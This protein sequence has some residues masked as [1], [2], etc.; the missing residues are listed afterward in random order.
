[1][2]NIHWGDGK[3]TPGRAGREQRLSLDIA[4]KIE[5]KVVLSDFSLNKKGKTSTSEEYGE[6]WAETYMKKETRAS[7]DRPQ[8]EVPKKYIYPDIG[9]GSR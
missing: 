1:M 4:K 2:G 6:G 9:T 8:E 7:T 3:R 5:G